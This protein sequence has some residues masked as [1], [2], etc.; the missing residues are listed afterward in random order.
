MDGAGAR[1][2]PGRL[3]SYA[4]RWSQRDFRSGHGH[5][6]GYCSRDGDGDGD[7]YGEGY[8]RG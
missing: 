6:H 1:R 8:G 4:G 3:H 5:G 2:R 7:S